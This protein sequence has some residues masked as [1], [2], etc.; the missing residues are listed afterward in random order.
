M[1]LL[2]DIPMHRY[3]E[4][5]WS[6]LTSTSFPIFCVYL[7]MVN[8][9]GTIK[10][11]IPI[12]YDLRQLM[13]VYNLVISVVNV[14]CF[15]G[16]M[17]CLLEAPSLYEKTPNA[18]LSFIFYVYW[19][20][21]VCELL[22]TVFMILRHR[23]RQI[24]PLHVY[25]HASMLLLSDLGYTRYAWA[26]FAMPLML[27][28]LA[29]LF[30]LAC[31]SSSISVLGV[32]VSEVS[33]EQPAPGSPKLICYYNFWSQYRSGVGKFTPED[34]DPELCTHIIVSFVKI[35]NGLLDMKATF[36]GS[37]QEE[38][39]EGI[40]GL[41][42]KNPA[43]KESDEDHFL[44]LHQTLRAGLEDQYLL[45]TVVSSK[46]TFFTASYYHL[47]E[48]SQVV[49]FLNIIT[50]DYHGH[51]DNQTGHNAPLFAPE[52]SLSFS[53]TLEALVDM[54]I[55]KDKIVLGFPTY[56]RSFT[57]SDSEA[58]EVGA[59][60][61]GPGEG[62]ELSSMPGTLTYYEI[63]KILMVQG[64]QWISFDDMSSMEAKAQVMNDNGL[65]NAFVWALGMDDFTGTQCQ[66]VMPFP[67]IRT[68]KNSLQ[69]TEEVHEE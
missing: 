69:P 17:Q 6:F 68:L 62:G 7:L 19:I 55:P 57:L 23:F 26:A 8:Q 5:G 51:W 54:D 18:K 40:K 65:H 61:E 44:S 60:T 35:K 31:L 42:S 16:F 52:G 2:Q 33:A 49:D 36:E 47:P 58:Q 56:G 34:I 43:L 9:L 3:R 32:P 21:K 45:G 25:H 50:Y 37:T 10:R 30:G 64:N 48:V 29:L 27:N 41:T 24:S 4:I 28:A 46:P 59:A 63:C 14:Y 11:A 66:D 1:E 38:L 15:V 12:P 67:L 39:L 53:D 20:T 13:G 22:D